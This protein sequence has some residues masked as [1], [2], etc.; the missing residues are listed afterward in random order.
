M[1]VVTPGQ[2][3]SLRLCDVDDV[4]GPADGILV[5]TLAVGVCGTDLEINVVFGSVNANRADYRTAATALAAPDPSWLASLM[6]RH[7]PLERWEEAY[8]R[9]SGDVKTV[10]VFG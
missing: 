6:T 3:G 1:R 10:L 9:Q 5:E 4:P 8:E 2:K 7:V